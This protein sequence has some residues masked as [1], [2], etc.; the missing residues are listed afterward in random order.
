MKKL[1]VFSLILIIHTG[2]AN[3]KV[4]PA[5]K[6]FSKYAGLS[7]D[8]IRTNIQL[9][10]NERESLKEKKPNAVKTPEINIKKEEQIVDEKLISKEELYVNEFLLKY[11]NIKKML[12]QL[13]NAGTKELIADIKFIFYDI[14]DKIKGHAEI[15]VTNNW[16]LMAYQIRLQCAQNL[17][18]LWAQ[19]DNP[20]DW[21]TARISIVD[22]NGNE[23][24]G[25]RWLAGSL[26]WVKE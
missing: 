25:S 9:E 24:G 26:I 19:I 14:N 1:Y 16:H 13:N 15:T 4:K 21:D 11:Q 7:K 20:K 2:C 18:K 10:I 23:V 5:N 8:E 6:A 17:W 22:Y 12:S 3:E